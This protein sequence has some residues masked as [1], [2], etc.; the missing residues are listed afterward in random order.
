MS[1]PKP[2]A[3][4]LKDIEVKR[5]EVFK[6]ILDN[7]YT[8]GYEWP[9]IDLETSKTITEF[10]VQLLSSYGK[11]IALKKSG[12]HQMAE[13]PDI[14]DK[15]TVGFNATVKKLEDQAAPNRAKLFTGTKKQ[16]RS[17]IAGSKS[18]VKYVFVTKNDISTPLLTNSFPLLTFCASQSNE[19]RVKLVELPRGSMAKLSKALNTDNVGF[20][21]LTDDWTEGKDM[22]NLINSRVGNVEVPWLSSLF[23]EHP[24]LGNLYER[25]AIKFLKTAAPVGKSRAKQKKGKEAQEEQKKREEKKNEE[26]ARGTKRQREW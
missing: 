7:P 13:K 23:D 6:P 17:S 2:G 10:L 15:L 24:S 22:F 8:K 21:S 3:G 14:C 25:P 12:A 18:Y 19:N 4:S 26:K 9:S 1:K 16:K 11:Y 20:L 5:R